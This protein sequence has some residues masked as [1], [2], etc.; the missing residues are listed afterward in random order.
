MI[1]PEKL[2][3]ELTVRLTAFQVLAISRKS[4]VLVN[5]TVA[6]PLIAC[7]SIAGYPFIPEEFERSS[8]LAPAM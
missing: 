2:G 7:N 6:A 3:V 8:A 4:S 1:R 5:A